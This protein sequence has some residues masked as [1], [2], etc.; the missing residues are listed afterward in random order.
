MIKKISS[1]SYSPLSKIFFLPALIPPLKNFLA[2]SPIPPSRKKFFLPAHIPL[3][4]FGLTSPSMK[5]F[6]AHVWVEVPGRYRPLCQWVHRST[7][8][9]SF[10]IC[11]SFAVKQGGT[12]PRKVLCVCAYAMSTYVDIYSY[13]TKYFVPLSIGNYQL[14]LQV[15][16]CHYS[17]KKYK[18]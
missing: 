12:T 1:P 18:D 9:V 8:H 5:N 4:N 2:P 11:Q 10:N 17:Q 6:L 13:V 7:T 16:L 3:K 15:I 14:Y